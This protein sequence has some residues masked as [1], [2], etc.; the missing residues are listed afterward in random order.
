MDR[1]KFD[2]GM[3]VRRAVL[4][5]KYVDNSLANADDFTRPLQELVTEGCWGTIWTRP[6][7]PLKTRS[8]V[9]VALLAALN[10]PHELKV[11]VRGAINNGCTQE[12]IQEVLLQVALY[13]GMPAG[14]DGFRTASE[15]LRAIASEQQDQQ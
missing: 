11:H 13:A 9:N 8:L 14:M 10:R 3:A 6:G 15:T 2:A 1:E 7:L 5:D 4:G 12:E